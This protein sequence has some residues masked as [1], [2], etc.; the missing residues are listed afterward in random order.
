M[1]GE[2]GTIVGVEVTVCARP[3]TVFRLLTESTQFARWMGAGSSIE[4][5]AGG[6]VRVPY[7]GGQ[8]ATGEVLEIV[9][10]ERIAFTYGYQ[11]GNRGV[12]SG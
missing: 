10:N 2:P 3:E 5:R 11:D 7:P 8:V 12:P 4:A 1:T 6:V 9:P